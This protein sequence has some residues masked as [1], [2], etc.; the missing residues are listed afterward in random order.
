MTSS[1]CLLL[2]VVAVVSVFVVLLASGT[3]QTSNFGVIVLVLQMGSVTQIV[4][5]EACLVTIIVADVVVRTIAGVGVA[6]LV[7]V[8]GSLLVMMLL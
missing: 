6:V 4:V 5:V 7:Y 3:P 8:A 1:V 2:V